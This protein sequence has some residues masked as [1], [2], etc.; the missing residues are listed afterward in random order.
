MI[1]WGISI[2][3]IDEFNF[4]VGLILEIFVKFYLRKNLST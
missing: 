1:F 3:I 2:Q 4:C